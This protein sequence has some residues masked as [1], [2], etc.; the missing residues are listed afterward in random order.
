MDP[1]HPIVPVPPNI[2]PVTPT[3][4]TG[5]IERDTPRQSLEDRRR[6][7]RAQIHD[8][9]DASPNPE[10]SPSDGDDSGLHI[11]VTA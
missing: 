7:K 11:N 5:R 2:P 8:T 3:P 1:I 4:L 9:P 10:Q 6:R